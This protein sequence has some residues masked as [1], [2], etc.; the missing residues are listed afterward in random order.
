[1]VISSRGQQH[2]EGTSFGRY[3]ACHRTDGFGRSRPATTTADQRVG[4]T[5]E[6]VDGNTIY[7][8]APDGRPITLKLA[9]SA[10]I[11]AVSKATFADI[12]PGDY[13]GTGAMPQPDGSQKAVELR[14]FP[15]PQAD[16]GHY[17]EGWYGA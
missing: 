6:R 9:D 16:G 13:V 15:K 10:A 2:D 8:K 17:Y 3:G 4:G 5:I 11:T 12:K 14:I 7:G 1:M